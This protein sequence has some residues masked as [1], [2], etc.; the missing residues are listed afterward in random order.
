MDSL[1]AFI[2]EHSPAVRALSTSAAVFAR[3][4]LHVTHKLKA[5]TRTIHLSLLRCIWVSF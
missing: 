1:D 2:N 3:T 5:A 4:L